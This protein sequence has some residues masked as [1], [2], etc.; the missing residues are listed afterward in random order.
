MIKRDDY[1]YVW[2]RLTIFGAVMSIFFA[3]IRYRNDFFLNIT[4]TL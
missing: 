3:L 4:L 2:L 1:F